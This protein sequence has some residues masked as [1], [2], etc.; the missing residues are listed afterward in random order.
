MNIETVKVKSCI[1]GITFTIEFGVHMR[2]VAVV[3]PQ[4]VK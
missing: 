4:D 2:S 1:Q 3:T